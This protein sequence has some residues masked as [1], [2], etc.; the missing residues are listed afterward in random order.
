MKIKPKICKQCG[1]AFYPLR[2]TPVC[3]YVC[4]LK[5]NE[6]KEVLKRVKQMKK[7]LVSPKDLEKVAKR[8]FQKWVRLRDTNLPCISCGTE[9]SKQWDGGH[10]KKAEIYSGVIFNEFNVNK[11]CSYCNKHL[12]G[13]ELNYR[14]GM[15]KKYGV[16]C[17]ESLESLANRTRQYRYTTDEL[18]EIIKTYK[19]KTKILLTK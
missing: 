9:T 18:L 8:V 12:H 3:S 2:I 16:G 6:E 1:K 10:Y 17:V 13:N 5:Y 19:E 15:I 7:D 14:A 11:Q 4:A